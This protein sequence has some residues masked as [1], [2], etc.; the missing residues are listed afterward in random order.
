MQYHRYDEAHV[1]VTDT[2][3]SS[4]DIIKDGLHDIGFRH[5]TFCE[6]AA[7][8]RFLIETGGVD[9]MIGDAYSAETDTVNL[10]RDLRDMRQRGDAFLPVMTLAWQPTIE[11]IHRIVNSGTDLILTL[12]MSVGKMRAAVD[13]LISRRKPFVVTSTYIGPDRRKEP[14]Q[15]SEDVPR[16]EVPNS[17]RKQ[18]T[19]QDDGLNPNRIMEMIREQRVERSAA[20]ITHTVGSIVAT[21]KVRKSADIGRL[22]SELQFTANDLHDRIGD[23]RY[24]HQRALSESLQEVANQ[25]AKS[26]DLT[27]SDLE[28]LPQLALALELAMG[29]DDANSVEAAL[30]ISRAVRHLPA[31]AQ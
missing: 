14:R 2:M 25:I 7:E 11:V 23:T 20:R 28:L 8:A 31:A 3:Q 29:A 18:V 13:T 24:A 21:V 5:I 27:D 16:I 9:V 17:L 12:P 1:I 19:G 22:I 30:D 6:G 26:G 10:I 4:R 15:D